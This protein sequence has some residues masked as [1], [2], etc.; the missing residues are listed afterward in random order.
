MSG[1]YLLTSLLVLILSSK[2][3]T[4]LIFHYAYVTSSGLC[5]ASCPANPICSGESVIAT[6]VTASPSDTV[7]WQIL[8]S[9]G[10]VIQ[11]VWLSGGNN[12]ILSAD[13]VDFYI[14]QTS[15]TT[16][17]ASFI[18]APS[19][20]NYWLICIAQHDDNTSDI[21]QNCSIDVNSK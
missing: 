9:N 14:N 13:G 1:D 2:C 16:S 6:C 10:V 11:T 17:I 20:D 19:I 18:T 15:N 21:R 4:T 8:N 5:L 12:S 3:Y 7:S